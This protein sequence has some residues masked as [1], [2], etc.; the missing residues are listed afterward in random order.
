ML[1]MTFSDRRL[2]AVDAKFCRVSSKLSMRSCE[3]LLSTTKSN[4]FRFHFSKEKTRRRD[5]VIDSFFSST[6]QNTCLFSCFRRENMIDDVL[7]F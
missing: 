7:L 2:F 5:L 6:T 3:K 4:G 1:S